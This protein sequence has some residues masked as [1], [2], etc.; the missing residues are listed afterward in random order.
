MISLSDN[1]RAAPVLVT[2]ATGY[3]AGQLVRRLLEEGLTVHAAVRDPS[4]HK[5]LAALKALEDSLPGKLRVFASDLLEQG[6]YA[7]AMAGCRVVFHTASPFVVSVEDPERDL[8]RPAVEG[9]RNVLQEAN[10]QSSVERV[11]LTSSC[12]AIYS[13]NA[14]A[15]DTP[16]GCFDESVWNTTA[17]LTHQAYSHSKTL[18][19]QAAWQ[20]AEQQTQWRLVVINP[21][22]VLGPAIDANATSQSI[23]IITQLCDGT[24]KVGVPDYGVGI[25]DIRDVAEAHVAAAFLPDARGRHLIAGHSSSFIELARLLQQHADPRYLI[26]SRMLPKWLVWLA[27]PLADKALTRKI[28]ARNVGHAFLFDNTR[29]REQL[30]LEYRPLAETLNDMFDQLVASGRLSK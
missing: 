14:D 23:N 9:T 29:S 27:G 13:D 26:P 12:A 30:G 5:R 4:D 17:S 15:L 19:E 21:A 1:D 18:A 2:G 11:V 20:I 10:R 3:V 24:L 16:R 7:E 6:S 8:V 22:L 28:V 25:V